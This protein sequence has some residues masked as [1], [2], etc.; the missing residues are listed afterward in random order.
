MTEEGRANDACYQ[1][2]AYAPGRE[3]LCLLAV[4][5]IDR[6]IA[7]SLTISPARSADI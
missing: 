7:E 2:S 5:H 1:E 3:V 4:G 6:E